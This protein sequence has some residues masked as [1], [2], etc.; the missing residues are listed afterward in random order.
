MMKI[1]FIDDEEINVELFKINFSIYFE[2]LTGLSG[3]EGLE[4]LNQNPETKVILTDL[5]MPGM[6]GIEFIKKAKEK[7]P[8]KTY[9][10]VTGFGLTEE[11]QDAIESG[12]IHRYFRKPFNIKEIKQ[13]INEK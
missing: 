11:I 13:A 5:K 3:L 6:N 12:L 7:F 4:L 9:F 2:V 8:N 10:I 1:L